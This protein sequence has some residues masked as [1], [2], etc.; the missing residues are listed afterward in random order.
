MEIVKQFT[1]N[2]GRVFNAVV[3][4]DKN[5]GGGPVVAFY[6][7]K[8][9]DKFGG[10]GQFTGGQYY[11]DTLLGEDKWSDGIVDGHGLCFD[12]GNADAWYLDEKP[13]KEVYTWLANIKKE[14]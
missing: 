9:I 4:E 5:Y 12:G 2:N 6:D 7:T 3:T 8:Y 11:I 13:A 14:L 1:N 10:F